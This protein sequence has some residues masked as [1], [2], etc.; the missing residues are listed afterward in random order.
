MEEL[1]HTPG[2]WRLDDN[3]HCDVTDS[4]Y[5]CI[6]AG[7]GYHPYGFHIAEF[8]READAR[9]IAAAPD[10]LEALIEMTSPT[11]SAESVRKAERAIAKATGQE[12]GAQ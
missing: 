1:K 3:V 4:K 6:D 9:L 2:P 5:H 11:V 7:N 10:L 12:A 8:L